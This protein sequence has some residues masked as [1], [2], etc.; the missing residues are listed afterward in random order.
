MSEKPHFMMESTFSG[1]TCKAGR[2]HLVVTGPLTSKTI[3]A[4]IKNMHLTKEMLA[5][6]EAEERAKHDPALTA[7]YGPATT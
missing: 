2:F 6:H 3:D 1:P 4:V 5:E 7:E